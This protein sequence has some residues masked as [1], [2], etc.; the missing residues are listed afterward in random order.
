MSVCVHW[1]RHRRLRVCALGF[2]SVVAVAVC[3]AV[4]AAWAVQSTEELRALDPPERGVIAALNHDRGGMPGA[5]GETLA[6]LA[7]SSTLTQAAS[8]YAEYLRATA[9]LS[10]HAGGTTPADRARAAGWT[11][12]PGP[13]L[14]VAENLYDGPSAA[15]A[16]A[17]WKT[18]PS[19]AAVLFHPGAYWV[20]LGRSANKWVLLVGGHC[21]QAECEPTGPLAFASAP[22]RPAHLRFRVRRLGRRVVVGVRVVR[23]EGRVRVRVR[24]SDGL[25]ARR[26]D[27]GREGTLWRY[28]F[29]LPETGRWRAAIRFLPDPGWTGLVVRSRFFTVLE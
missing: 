1:S 26:T 14:A 23:G 18:S 15:A 28:R 11:P 2:L 3:G 29:R 25:S 8:D 5:G 4:P 7:I 19:H 21:T 9:Q 6:P 10:H 12:L 16:Y 20:G 27:V 13:G 17:A 22:P 24:R